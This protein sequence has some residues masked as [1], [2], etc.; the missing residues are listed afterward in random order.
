MLN[1]ITI[2]GL[3]TR[4]PE[5]RYTPNNTPV[6][7]FTVAVDRDYQSGGT[8][9]QTDFINCVAWR[10]TG[11]FVSKYFQKGSMIVV[12]GRLQ[13]RSYQDKDGNN[14]TVAEVV[15]DNVYFGESKRSNDVAGRSEYSA[16]APGANSGYAG[17]N[18]SVN[19]SASPQYH[20]T[21][22]TDLPDEDDG[23]LPF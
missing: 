13:I 16:P 10:S 2:M 8:E 15:A 3:L 14:R 17:A 23:D 7:S 1:H 12:S 6:A 5:L 9:K 11:E 18:Q 19:A 21:T 20:Q 22:F 4:D